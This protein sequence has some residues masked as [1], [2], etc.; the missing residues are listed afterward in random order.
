MRIAIVSCAAAL[1]LA[2]ALPAHAKDEFE[3]GFKDELGRIA[4]RT[5]VSGARHLIVGL[6]SA[7]WSAARADPVE[8]ADSEPHRHYGRE[9]GE[10]RDRRHD[11]AWGHYDHSHGPYGYHCHP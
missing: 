2:C 6:L 10:H 1:A 5:A 4:A 7:D 8:P 3:D 9:H 11:P